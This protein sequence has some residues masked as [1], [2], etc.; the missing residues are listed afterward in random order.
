MQHPNPKSPQF[1]ALN[2]IQI[3]A[4]PFVDAMETDRAY[5]RRLEPDRFLCWFRT[6]AGL[7]PNGEVYGGWESQGVAGQTLGHYLSALCLMFRASG[8]EEMKT[9]ADYIVSELAECQRAN[10]DGYVAATPNGKEIYARIAAGDIQSKGGF[11]LNG[12]W[13]PLYTFHKVLAG[14]LDAFKLCENKQALE[15]ATLLADW[16]ERVFGGLPHEQ[17]QFVLSV[18]HGGMAESLAELFA[19]TGEKRYLDLARRFRHDEFFV[20]ALENRD[21]L[22]GRHANTQIPKFIGYQRLHEVT[23]EEDW[24]L[25]ARH[26]WNFVACNRSFAI[27]GNSN[28]E[29]FFPIDKFETAMREGTGPETCNTYNMLKLTRQLWAQNPDAALMDFAE[30]ALWNHILTSQHPG[31]GFVYYTGVRPESLRT[32]SDD[33]HSFWCCVGTG[34]ENHARYGETIYAHQNDTLWVNQFIASKL[35]W[36]EQNVRVA[37]QTEF[38]LEPRTQLRFEMDSPREFTLALRYPSWIEV[39]ALKIAINGED[40]FVD[41]QPGQYVE[42]RREWRSGDV[43]TVELPM[44]L[45]VELLPGSNNFAAILCGPI[46]LAGVHEDADNTPLPAARQPCILVAPSEIAAHFHPVEGRALTFQS[47]DLSRPDEITLVPFYNLHDQRYTLYFPLLPNEAA[48]QARQSEFAELARQQEIL[49]ARTLDEVRAGEQQSE[50]DHE[51]AG[52]KT[53]SG[54]DNERGWRHADDGGWFSY[55]LKVEEAPLELLCTYWSGDAPR[56]FE[57]WVDDVLLSSEQ[58]GGQ[59]PGEFVDVSHRLEASSTKGKSAVAV[60]WRPKAGSVAGLN[61]CRVLRIEDAE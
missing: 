4:K 20:P 29:H 59:S 41:E 1:F 12:G 21:E 31:G 32:Y 5:L 61:R 60:K 17:M 6:Q 57:V 16:C 45:R 50:V 53:T 13:V 42:I 47:H 40:R 7:E 15:V 9:R 44:K 23:G 30:R 24:H 37:Q 35:N 8:D 14:L 38:P 58:I 46:V 56:E 48:W 39:G 54:H 25:A 3:T 52:E 19:L 27:G 43:L 51:F 36:R 11:D 34:M 55:R 10:G 18:E 26:F 22:N 49:A 33:C 2:D 28:G